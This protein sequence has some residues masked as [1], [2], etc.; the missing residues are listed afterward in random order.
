MSDVDKG[1]VL[2]TLA[3]NAI[4]QQ[5][6]APTRPLD[7]PDW[8]SEPGA[9]FV[10]LTRQ[11]K[12][13]GCIGSLT[14]RRPLGRDVVHNACDAAFRDSRFP[15]L[16]LAELSGTRVEVSL[17][18]PLEAM[19]FGDEAD[20]MARLRPGIDGVVLECGG[21]RGTF[22][23]QVWD[24]LPQPGQFLSEL[25]RKAGLAG[26]FWSPAVKLQ[27]YTVEKWKE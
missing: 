23:P 3:R 27:R 15:P 8:L 24:Q 19:R 1:P 5:L 11:G 18:S 4:A 20:A 26:T 22:L 16:D 9:C 17:L 12:L 10:T 21:H 6:G 14:A 13:R 25:K 7:E 2:L